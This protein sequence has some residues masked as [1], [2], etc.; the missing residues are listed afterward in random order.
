MLEG[1]AAQWRLR[2]EGRVDYLY[3]VWW[4]FG[5]VWTSS[6]EVTGR[7]LVLPLKSGFI[8]REI[9]WKRDIS[10]IVWFH[11]VGSSSF[12]GVWRGDR[13]LFQLGEIIM[14]NSF[15][16]YSFIRCS[17]LCTIF[18][19][20]DRISDSLW[21]S[22]VLKNKVVLANGYIAWHIIARFRQPM[23]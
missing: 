3:G 16:C 17:P 23:E 22:Q 13:Y 2:V 7:Y 6:I 9:R 14:F 11:R 10:R 4:G 12:C 5:V 8:V 1:K 21:F 15:N 19:C 18:L 20:C